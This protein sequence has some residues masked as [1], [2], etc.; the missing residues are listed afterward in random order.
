[1]YLRYENMVGFEYFFMVLKLIEVNWYNFDRRL[2]F[3]LN[4]L[5]FLVWEFEI[6]IFCWVLL[7]KDILVSIYNKMVV[8]CLIGVYLFREIKMIIIFV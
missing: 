2:V 4:K 1:M 8:W 3:L 6:I 5:R 7:S